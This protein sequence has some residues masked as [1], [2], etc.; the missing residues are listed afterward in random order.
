MSTPR[1]FSPVVLRSLTLP[2]RIVVAPMCQYAAEAG[3]AGDW[4]R[5]HYG[6]LAASGPGLIVLEATGVVPEGRISP[7]C[8]GLYDD[9]CEEA[10]TGL[11]RSLKSVGDSRIGVQLAHAGRKGSSARP[12][13]SSG[14]A[15]GGEGWETVSSS[16]V[17]FDAHWP[18]PRELAQADLE[19]LTVAFADAARRALRVGFDAIEVH[20]AHGYLLHQ[21]LSPLVNRRRDG[22]GGSLEGRMRFPL[23]VI[24]ATRAAWP[25]DKPLGIRISA[26][27]WLEGG[28][29]PDEA[30]TYAKTFK[31]EGIDFVCVSSGGI[32]GQAPIP[33]GPGY[34]V[35]LAERIRRETGLPVRAVG[36]IAEPAF[37]ESLLADGKADMIALGRGFL[38]NPRW[39]W[40]AAE[41][42]G[43]DV[44]YPPRYVRAKRALWPGAALARPAIK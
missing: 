25:S 28:F 4:H 2:N 1:L 44:P 43:Y 26:T 37:A 27:D 19:R 30:V 40:H 29:T 23:E 31:K 33:V 8:L 14:P 11:V 5:Q 20:S 13:Q 42:L 6:A 34:Q 16:A 21:F 38:D 35:F 15:G 32:V 17:P 36:L 22:Y 10:M 24:R 9:A 7:A 3:R 18:T 41:A 12:W 39:V